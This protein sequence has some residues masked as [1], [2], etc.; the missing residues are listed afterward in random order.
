MGDKKRR[1]SKKHQGKKQ[2]QQI[3]SADNQ[4]DYDN[5][6]GDNTDYMQR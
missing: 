6:T 5:R 2:E 3:H 1:I 4:G